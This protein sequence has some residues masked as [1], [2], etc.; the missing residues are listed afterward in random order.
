MQ[1][2]GLVQG[3][4]RGVTKGISHV[5]ASHKVSVVF[6]DPNRVGSAGPVPMLRLAEQAGL[7]DLTCSGSI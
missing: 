4:V 2:D 5:Q 6:D 3:P 1:Q 7:H